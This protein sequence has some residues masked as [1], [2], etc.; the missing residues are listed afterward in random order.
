[1]EHSYPPQDEAAGARPII[2][3]RSYSDRGFAGGNNLC[4]QFALQQGDASFIWLLNNDTLQDSA[5]LTEL[6]QK[7]ADYA[8]QRRK[9]G[10]IGSKLYYYHMPQTIQ[11][12]GGM[13]NPKNTWSYHLGVREADAGQ[14]DIDELKFD[15]VY[16]ASLFCRREFI[17]EVGL[18]NE[19]YYAYY[20]EIDWKLRG[21]KSGWEMGYA[22]KSRIWH[23]QGVTTGKKIKSKKRPQFF[24]CLKYVNL[25]V[26]YRMYY[27][28]YIFAAYTRLFLKALKNI[29]EGNF[30]ETWL[31]IRI[32]FGKRTCTRP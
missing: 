5:A 16:G 31:I 14:Y 17:E 26:F 22:W 6:V 23:K 28:Q 32:I 29:P 8:I 11:A 4:T 21:E 18:M 30:S 27:P 2:F 24:M 1:V 10:I 15:Y 19:T 20:E 13:F 12:V 25:L 7:A 3:I 9:V